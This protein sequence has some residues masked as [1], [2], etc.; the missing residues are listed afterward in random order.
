[1]DDLGFYR[2][3]GG[4]GL[5]VLNE[6]SFEHEGVKYHAIHRKTC[7]ECAFEFTEPCTVSEEQPWCMSS[8]RQDGEDVIWQKQEKSDG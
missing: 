3:F 4:V 7:R 2:R 5:A 6:E 8:M 1:M